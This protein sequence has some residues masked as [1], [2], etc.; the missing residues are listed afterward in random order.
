MIK[1]ITLQ[2]LLREALAVQPIQ[3]QPLRIKSAKLIT[4]NMELRLPF[5]TSFARI[6][7]LPKIFVVIT[8]MTKK[9]SEISGI[10]ESPFLP[11]PWYDGEHISGGKAVLKECIIP[12]LENSQSAITNVNEFISLYKWIVGNTIAKVGAE[13]AY[14]DAV[15]KLL[16]KPVWKL[17]NGTQN[18][19]VC[20]TS[21]GLEKTDKEVVEKIRKNL[22]QKV[23]RI[24][25]KIKPG[26][27]ISL[28]QSI[29]KIFP[30][31]P[32]Q[33]DGNAAYD[34]GN[35][36]HKALLKALDTFDLLMIEQPGPNDDIYFHSQLS[37][38]LK[39]PLCL[40]ESILHARHAWEAITLWNNSNIL[41]RLV[42]N[43]KPPRV[44]GFWEAVK[45]ATLC[46]KVGVK[47]WCGGM[48]ESAVGKTANVHLSTL[49]GFI[50]PGDHVSFPSYFTKDIAQS[51]EFE[52]GTLIAP[53]DN[54]WGLQEVSL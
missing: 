50:L 13:G 40:D 5:E 24:K 48:L 16:G 18:K 10:G 11:A 51:P 21:I 34:L 7:T 36:D 39:T 23:K 14:W 52:D 20:G 1:E 2:K 12:A 17:W 37:K 4:K 49:P 42:I 35:A 9:G 46:Q 19:V 44:G 38:S 26:R 27:D 53:I 3:H 22:A 47:I 43:I 30:Q 29:R 25:I 45:I 28:V 32:L 8:F 6:T 41:D 31:I 15:G 54:G 33:V